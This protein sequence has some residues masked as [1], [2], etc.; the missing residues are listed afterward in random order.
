MKLVVVETTII[1][2]ERGV[3]IAPLSS[4][5]IPYWTVA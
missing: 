5:P 2:S 3:R 1:T 4:G